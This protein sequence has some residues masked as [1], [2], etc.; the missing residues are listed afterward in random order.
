MLNFNAEIVD[1]DETFILCVHVLG[2]VVKCK[3]VKDLE[4]PKSLFEVEQVDQFRLAIVILHV[5][6]SNNSLR[7][8]PGSQILQR[9]LSVTLVENPGKL[10]VHQLEE[11]LLMNALFGDLLAISLLEV[12]LKL[13]KFLLREDHP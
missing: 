3:L 8:K 7:F 2:E 5:A 12:L 11:L 9:F 10:R 1:G 4:L 6:L 13:L